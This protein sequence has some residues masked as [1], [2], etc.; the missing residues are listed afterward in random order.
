[1]VVW[2]RHRLTDIEF[3]VYLKGGPVCVP[4]AL[5]G[6]HTSDVNYRYSYQ[7]ME[8]H[9]SI[10]VFLLGLCFLPGDP[11]EDGTFHLPPLKLN[12]FLDSDDV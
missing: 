4:S 7:Y 2:N 8:S 3:F 1:M 11:N 12:R 5:I 9:S 10:D 6:H